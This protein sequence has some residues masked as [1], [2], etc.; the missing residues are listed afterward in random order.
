MI[1]SPENKNSEKLKPG[2]SSRG[3]QVLAGGFQFPEN[4]FWVCS[5]L[6][7]LPFHSSL[8]TILKFWTFFSTLSRRRCLSVH[9]AT[10]TRYFLGWQCPFCSLELDVRVKQLVA[11]WYTWVLVASHRKYAALHMWVDSGSQFKEEATLLLGRISVSP[12][13]ISPPCSMSEF[14]EL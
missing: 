8:G 6:F 5:V 1:I 11:A 3:R 7:L 13:S 10:S 2:S 12:Y 9:M 4:E 14:K